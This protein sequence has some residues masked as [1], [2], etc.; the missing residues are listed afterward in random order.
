MKKIL[1]CAL[2]AAITI[3]VRAQNFD[4]FSKILDKIETNN[5]TVKNYD[6]Y[7]L[8]GKNFVVLTNAADH[9]ERHV[10]QFLSDNK[11]QIVELIDDKKTGDHFSNIFSGDVVRNHNKLSVRADVLEGQK[12]PVPKVYNFLLNFYNGYWYLVDINTNEKWVEANLL[13][14]K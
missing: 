3:S 12:I 14:K 6:N 8:E 2:F 7:V 11:V 9:S 5:K 4:S 13:E 10:I 1:I